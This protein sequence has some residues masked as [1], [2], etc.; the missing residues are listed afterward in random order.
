MT[1][2]RAGSQ[3]VAES[4]AASGSDDFYLGSV[5]RFAGDRGVPVP[6]EETAAAD[7]QKD[8]PVRRAAG[9]VFLQVGENLVEQGLPADWSKTA[10]VVEAFGDAY[11]ALLK[12][13]PKLRDVLAL[14]S[15]IVF[16]D[17]ARIVHVQPPAAK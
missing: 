4:K 17:G 14:G 6:A 5:R 9:R 16:R 3:A 8:A 11:F 10:V 15:R 13:D 1:G 2:A 12:A 7:A